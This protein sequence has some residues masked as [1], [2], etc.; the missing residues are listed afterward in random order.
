M[1]TEIL[2]R[3]YFFLALKRNFLL[4]RVLLYQHQH[5]EIL[6]EVFLTYGII[7]GSISGEKFAAKRSCSLFSVLLP[8]SF[9]LE[10]C[11]KCFFNLLVLLLYLNLM[12]KKSNSN[13]CSHVLIFILICLKKNY[14][15]EIQATWADVTKRL[16]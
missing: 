12:F 2:T 16:K 5:W 13:H 3:I 4:P 11:G 8:P 10:S 15:H 9:P 1:D 14:Y 6:L 7:I